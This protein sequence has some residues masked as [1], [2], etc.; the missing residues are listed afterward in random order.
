MSIPGLTY[1]N[2]SQ[3]Y[4]NA[5]QQH[6]LQQNAN[7]LTVGQAAAH[8]IQYNPYTDL[9]ILPK[10]DPKTH[11]LVSNKKP[12]EGVNMITEVV[13]D[14]KQFVRDHKSTVY[15]IAILLIVDHFM[16]NG[17]MKEKLQSL[18]QNLIGKVEAKLNETEVK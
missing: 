13:K 1:N 11:Y 18:M 3:D 14:L 16:F 15:V 2:L 10:Y 7:T 17:A 6:S 12:I 5:L 4:Q 8:F 9:S